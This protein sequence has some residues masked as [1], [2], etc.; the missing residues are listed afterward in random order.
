M[1]R[2]DDPALQDPS[3]AAEL[4][5]IIQ[6]KSRVMSEYKHRLEIYNGSAE[7]QALAFHM[8]V[9]ERRMRINALKAQ[10]LELYRLH[11]EHKIADDVLNQVLAE[12]DLNEANLGR[13]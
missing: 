3:D 13:P 9:V 2:V 10:R 5:L 1:E 8:E 6:A 7:A 4:V 12:L 11:K